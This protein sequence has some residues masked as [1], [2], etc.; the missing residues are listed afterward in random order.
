MNKIATTVVASTIALAGLGLAYAGTDRHEGQ[1]Y[2]KGKHCNY[3]KHGKNTEHYIQRMTKQLGLSEDQAAQVKTIKE[4][5]QPQKQQLRSAMMEKRRA[6]KDL[7]KTEPMDEA[8]VQQLAESMGQLKTD[9]IILKSKMISEIN[10]VLTAEQR[11]KRNAMK[12]HR[13]YKHHGHGEHH[14]RG[15]KGDTD[16]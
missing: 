11:E 15:E 10:Q 14:E 5:Y 1:E 13:G 8:G 16:S 9:K 6:L 7:M 2:S 3:G 4:K 12:H